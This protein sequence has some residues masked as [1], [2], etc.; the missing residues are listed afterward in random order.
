MSSNHLSKTKILTSFE[1][2]P[3]MI[4]TTVS[5]CFEEQVQRYPQYLAVQTP[6]QRFTYEAL[7]RAANQ[8]ASAIIEQLGEGQARVASLLQTHSL[9]IPALFGILKA[10]KTWVP[11][12]PSYPQAR[13]AYIFDDATV[14]LILTDNDSLETAQTLAQSGQIILNVD[15]LASTL[16]QENPRLNYSPDDLAFILYTSG[17]TGQP[18]GVMENH[19]TLLH[20]VFA[21]IHSCGLVPEDR[22]AL[23]T[24]LSFVAGF[25]DVLRALLSGASISPYHLKSRGLAGLADWLIIERITLYHFVPTVF[26]HFI[27]I[28]TGQ[29]FSDV[30]LVHLGGEAV[31]THDFALFKRYFPANCVL[32]NNISSTEVSCYRQFFATHETEIK[33]D[34]MPIGYPVPDKQVSLLD[35]QGQPTPIGEVGEI[36]VKSPYLALGYWGRPELTTQMFLSDREGSTNRIYHTGDL[37]RMD[38]D[39]CL[40][41][42]GRKDNQVKVRGQRVDLGEIEATLHTHPSVK[43]V[44]I[45]ARSEPEINLAA[46]IVPV[47][48]QPVTDETLRSDLRQKLPD[49][50]IPASFTLLDEMPLL[51][52]GKINRVALSKLQPMGPTTPFVAP[53]TPTEV[54][55]VE[56][57]QTILNVDR[58]GINDNFFTLGGHSILAMQIISR[59]PDLFE[60]T[61]SADT[62]FDNPTI[63]QLAVMITLEQA[64]AIDGESL[65]DL[66]AEL[67]N[68]PDDI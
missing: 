29:T 16:S 8:I 51:P 18:K 43:E 47:S 12:D 9:T 49:Y 35:E 63:A 44:A 28:L 7:N 2:K 50:M 48:A 33:G 21:Y 39:G 31:S 6:T 1:L 24:S 34:L 59:I 54:Q 19:R 30:R 37:G 22:L 5:A 38:A 52:N 64:E 65:D 57:W 53:Q 17:S 11:I 10:G 26:R 25:R 66:L 4:E 55:L 62:L 15:Q 56:L 27:D 61:L 32:L 36:V 42:L 3:E 68:L 60:V 23:L 14:S 67:E 20:G 58:I 40:Y 41:H 13:I 45:I 46:Y